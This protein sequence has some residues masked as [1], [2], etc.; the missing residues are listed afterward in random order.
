MVTSFFLTHYFGRFF[1]IPIFYLP[2]YFAYIFF[3]FSSSRNVYKVKKTFIYL[4]SCM[5][6]SIIF[7]VKNLTS[8]SSCLVY[9]LMWTLNF[10]VANYIALHDR[11]FIFFKGCVLSGVF[12]MIFTFILKSTGYDPAQYFNRPGMNVNQ[13]SFVLIFPIYYLIKK[14]ILL[15]SLFSIPI[16]FLLQSRMFIL[17]YIISMFLSKVRF[18]IF[19]LSGSSILILFVLLNPSIIEF[20]YN[21]IYAFLN[22][23]FDYILG[24]NDERR[25]SLLFIGLYI[26]QDLFPFG[27]GFGLSNYFNYSSNYISFYSNHRAV[28]AHN[29]YITYLG[30]MGVFFI[31]FL[32][33]L[34][35]PLFKSCNYFFPLII[36]FLLAIAFNEYISS[37]FFWVAYGSALSRYKFY[38]SQEL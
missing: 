17:K 2:I 15:S 8:W 1:T 3:D 22:F 16:C 33:S 35:K 21:L 30:I 36:S 14:G 12:L 7:S 13:I 6:L 27:S 18:R 34:I 20:T 29:F 38:F 31:P 25:I 10:L 24:Y 9:I 19:L 4:F 5:I 11:N 32:Y 28:L 23:N 26:V 37:P